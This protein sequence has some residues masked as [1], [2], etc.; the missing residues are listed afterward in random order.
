MEG[1]AS[2][3]GAPSLRGTAQVSRPPTLG[4]G[5]RT[6]NRGTGNPWGANLYYSTGSA[7]GGGGQG[8]EQTRGCRQSQG[9]GQVGEQHPASAWRAG[10]V[11]CSSGRPSE[12]AVDREGLNGSAH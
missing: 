12:Q 8:L 7:G 2:A 3:R 5:Q 9:A 11:G 1:D 6:K 10:Q 4:T